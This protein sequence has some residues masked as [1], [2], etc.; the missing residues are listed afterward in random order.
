MTPRKIA[1]IMTWTE[2][3]NLWI[4]RSRPVQRHSQIQRPGETVL[5]SGLE[6]FNLKIILI[7]KI[8]WKEP[9]FMDRI[10]KGRNLCSFF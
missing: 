4:D 2:K 10:N 5:I 6:D 3:L 7:I 9:Q 8:M 1:W